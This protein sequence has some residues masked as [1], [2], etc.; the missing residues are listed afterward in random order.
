LKR[1]SCLLLA[2]WALPAAAQ[3]GNGPWNAV[4]VSVKAMVHRMLA[5]DGV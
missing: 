1:L 3:P 2:G 5:R 4:P